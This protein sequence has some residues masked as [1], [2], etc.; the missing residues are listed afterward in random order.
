MKGKVAIV[1]GGAGGLGSEICRKFASRGASVAVADVN[2]Q[3]AE[4]S[5]SA[6]A[7]A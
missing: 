1:T 4:R 3:E 5:L 2:A 6:T 7:S